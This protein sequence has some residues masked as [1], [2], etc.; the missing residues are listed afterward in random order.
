[1]QSFNKR[2]AEREQEVI[3]EIKL[4]GEQEFCKHE[5]IKGFALQKWFQKQKGCRNDSIY[6]YISS[7]LPI[8]DLPLA[9]Q[10]MLAIQSR[11]S[12]YQTSVA[13]YQS[14]LE[15]TNRRIKVLEEQLRYYKRAEY[16]ELKPIWE[17]VNNKGDPIR[18]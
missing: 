16:R 1:M 14:R 12:K 17:L 9:K 13:D 5:G 6:N 4:F 3:D 10:I 15:E 8:H 2:F 7:D 11:D 18:R